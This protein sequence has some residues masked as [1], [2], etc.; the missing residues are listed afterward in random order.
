MPARRWW[1][2]GA[3]AAGIAVAIGLVTLMVATLDPE[4]ERGIDTD[5]EERPDYF[6]EHFT[7]YTFRE[8]G[9]PH[10]Q[11]RGD[12]AYHYP[13][14]GTLEI[15]QPR[16]QVETQ[17]GAEWHARAPFGIARTA[18]ETVDLLEDVEAVRLPWQGRPLL[19]VDTRNLHVR[20]A[21]DRADTRERATAR[22]PAGQASG[23]GM[24]VF[25]EEDRL[26]W[27]EEAR[28]RYQGQR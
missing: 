9:E 10:A 22:E 3:T 25:F 8:N 19:E 1:S 5:P 16:L 2:T 4:D 6:L 15:T 17:A 24:T 14:R 23:L 21:E 27:H 12:D 26:H 20:L 11:L 7:T 28:G 13:A 18:E